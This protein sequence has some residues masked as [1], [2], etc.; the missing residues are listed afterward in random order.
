MNKSAQ[1]QHSNFHQVIINYNKQTHIQI[2]YEQSICLTNIPQH[3]N[4]K[5]VVNLSTK[6]VSVLNKHESILARKQ[7][8]LRLG[9]KI[10]ECWETPGFVSQLNQLLPANPNQNEPPDNIFEHPIVFRGLTRLIASDTVT[11]IISDSG[12][13]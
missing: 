9:D 6:P 7:M 3:Q 13:G 8:K 12:K 10:A 2:M 4:W 1:L 5:S 11:R